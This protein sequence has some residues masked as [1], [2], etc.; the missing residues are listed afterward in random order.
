M[1]FEQRYAL[2]ACIVFLIE[3]LIATQLRAWPWVRGHLGDVLVVVLMPLA[4]GAGC[5]RVCMFGGTGSVC[6]HQ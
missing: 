1:R 2:I 3:V 6:G 4:S 5:L